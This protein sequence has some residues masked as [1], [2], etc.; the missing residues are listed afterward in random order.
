MS[1][2]DK[3][4]AAARV[5][6]WM[7]AAAFGW[8]G[9]IALVKHLSAEIE[10]YVLLFWRYFLAHACSVRFPSQNGPRRTSARR[11]EFGRRQRLIPKSHRGLW[12]P[13]KLWARLDGHL[14][15]VS[16]F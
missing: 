12:M 15:V 8:A 13:A 3:V 14:V 16:E 9:M 2:G 5:G 10:V 6:L 1:G 4:A 11:S 7:A